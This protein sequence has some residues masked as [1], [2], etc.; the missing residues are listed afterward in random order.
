MPESAS[1]P[2]RVPKMDRAMI[3]AVSSAMAG[4]RLIASPSCQPASMSV[5]APVIIGA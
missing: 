3:C 2:S 4:S 5:T 1:A